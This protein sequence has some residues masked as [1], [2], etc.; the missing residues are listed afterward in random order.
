MCME[1]IRILRRMQHRVIYASVATA[2]PPTYIEI[3]ANPN[4]IKLHIV[5]ITSS[6][7]D[8][9]AS[10]S[11]TGTPV[12]VFQIFSQSLSSTSSPNAGNSIISIESVGPIIMNRLWIYSLV[13]ATTVCISET[14][15]LE[16]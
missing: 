6:T 4:R 15:L 14:S 13:G 3:P 12:P 16:Q 7:G 5:S 10:L 11:P 9:Y 2:G 8:V 1:D